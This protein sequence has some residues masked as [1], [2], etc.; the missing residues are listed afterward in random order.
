[1]LLVGSK[2]CKRTLKD[3]VFKALNC[4]NRSLVWHNW[5]CTLLLVIWRLQIS[6]EGA[7]LPAMQCSQSGNALGKR[8]CEWPWD[9]VWSGVLKLCFFG[10]YREVMDVS[11]QRLGKHRS[12]NFTLTRTWHNSLHCHCLKLSLHSVTLDLIGYT[13]MFSVC[14]DF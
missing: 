4:W 9:T 10:A 14:M 5:S 3:L 11:I 6:V 8:N 13:S 7:K 1:M 2:K 12:N